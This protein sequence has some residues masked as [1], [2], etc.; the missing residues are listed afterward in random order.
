MTS[1]SPNADEGLIPS[2]LQ[3]QAG[4]G[5]FMVAVCKLDGPVPIRPPQSPQLKPFTFFMTRASQPDGSKQLFL[6]MGYFDTLTD[7]EG[8]ARLARR[9]YPGAF[10][11]IAPGIRSASVH[12]AAPASALGAFDAGLLTPEAVPGGTDQSLSDTQVLKILEARHV[13]SDR[14]EATP[15]LD[16]VAL[17]SPE[18]T[19]TRL[20]L[21]EAVVQGAPVCFAVQLH[22][23]TEPIDVSRVRPLAL[24]EALTLYV[25][26]SRRRGRCRYFLRVGFFADPLSAKEVA[27]QVR[28]RFDSAAVVPVI[29]PEITRAREAGMG[30]SVIP[31][32]AEPPV[33]LYY[34]TGDLADPPY[35]VKQAA[36]GGPRN[37]RR[38]AGSERS[39]RGEIWAESDTLSES[40]VRHLR[41]EALDQMSGRWKRIR[42]R[43]LAPNDRPSR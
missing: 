8:W 31:C 25:T 24:S 3:A 21:K 16:Q 1:T 20:A 30:R 27:V 42:L 38:V 32:L 17:L 35:Q 26:Q 19:G 22:W 13:P 36:A 5:R 29:E 39:V 7:A 10:A 33:D 15:D 4:V 34:E 23:S 11:T 12:P 6:N 18:D 2:L 9:H 40:G 43:D 14:A 41:I 28:T 37:R